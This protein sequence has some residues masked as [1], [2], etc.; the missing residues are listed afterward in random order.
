MQ[1]AVFLGLDEVA[2]NLPELQ[3]IVQGVSMDAEVGPAYRKLDETMQAVIREMVRTGDRRF[4]GAMLQT[5][6]AYPDHPFG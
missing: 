1:N 5:L 2:A 6:L 3:E 4:L